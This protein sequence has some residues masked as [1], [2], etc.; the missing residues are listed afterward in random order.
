MPAL[1]TIC[2]S[3][4]GLSVAVALP[5]LVHLVRGAHVAA[6]HEVLRDR[7]LR[8]P[9]QR[10][11]RV[12]LLAADAF[13]RLEHRHR[14]ILA[15]QAH[16]LSGAHQSGHVRRL[17]NLGRRHGRIDHVGR[18]HRIAARHRTLRADQR[19]QRAG[20]ASTGREHA[21]SGRID[22]VHRIHLVVAGVVLAHLGEDRAVDVGRRRCGDAL[23]DA[24]QVRAVAVK[25][26]TE[27]LVD[28]VARADRVVGQHVA[29]QP[30][31]AV[32]RGGQEI[33]LSAGSADQHVRAGDVAAA[34]Q[35][36]ADEGDHAGLALQEARRS[37]SERLDVR[38]QRGAGRARIGEQAV[39]RQPRDRGSGAPEPLREEFA[40]GN[41]PPVI[42]MAERFVDP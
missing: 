1:P 22:A 40:P 17:R 20:I 25:R 13:D 36:E 24:A 31:A 19:Q 33:Q 7:V 15:Q 21:E 9:Q 41:R 34:S 28:E 11:D 12:E 35:V 5:K 3:R 38:R 6:L 42:R 10:V 30:Q 32:A 4:S 2:G 29:R 8:R 23:L 14:V 16:E 27:R 39:H 26:D 18:R 37:G